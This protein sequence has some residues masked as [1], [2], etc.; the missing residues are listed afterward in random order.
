MNRVTADGGI[1]LTLP[2]SGHAQDQ[3]EILLFDLA[4]RKL[5][6]QLPMSRVVLG[7]DHEP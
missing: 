5:L 3:G 7:H 4:A 1:D 6:H 2:R